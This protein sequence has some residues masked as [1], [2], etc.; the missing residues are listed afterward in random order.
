MKTVPPD[1]DGAFEDAGWGDAPPPSVTDEVLG[2]AGA[3]TAGLIAEGSTWLPPDASPV[4]DDATVAGLT[5]GDADADPSATAGAPP[6]V[7]PTPAADDAAPVTAVDDAPVAPADAVPPG[8]PLAD[9]LA[10]DWLP[11]VELVGAVVD[12]AA[13]GAM[14]VA[15]VGA[16][17]GGT[18]AVVVGTAFAGGVPP[19]AV[20]GAVVDV[21]ADGG[22]GE[23][24]VT[25]LGGV[26]ADGVDVAGLG[27]G[28]T[29]S[30]AMAAPVGAATPA[31]ADG[32][33][34]RSASSTATPVKAT[35]SG[36]LLDAVAIPSPPVRI[37]VKLPSVT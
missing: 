17:A 34:H 26:V 6:Q 23:M 37:A 29:T 18:V 15:E 10:Q 14:V 2:R 4:A 8:D 22:V 1:P 7:E 19:V 9:E 33:V 16:V 24:V 27:A 12:E 30:V 35:T 13:D 3:S 5:A 11:V 25:A 32:A 31:L 28:W 36:C 20:V 21:L